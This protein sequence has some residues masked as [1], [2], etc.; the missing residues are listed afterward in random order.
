MSSAGSVTNWIHQLQAGDRAA[1][2]KLWECY[3]QRLVSLAR[4][5][6]RAAPRQ[7]ADEEDVALSAF[8]S[9]CRRAEKGQFPDLHDRDN[10][11]QLLVSITLRKAWNLI[12][13]ER[14]QKRGGGRVRHASA[15]ESPEGGDHPL[16]NLM[17][18]E[19]NP[20]LAVQMADEYRRLMTILRDDTLRSIAGWKMDGQANQA[21][22]DRLGRSLGTVERK[23]RLI[24]KTWEKEITP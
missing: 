23:L 13:H 19:P 14:T 17:S 11:W 3:F 18:R 4:A 7:A 24:R 12:E 5:K 20:L 16:V 2:G 22:A 21:I 15:L 10:L 6:L 8:E 9:F 1:I